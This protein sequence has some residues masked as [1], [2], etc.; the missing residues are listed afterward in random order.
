M[1]ICLSHSSLKF[2][3]MIHDRELRSLLH[4]FGLKVTAARLRVLGV[5]VH[6]PVAL[7]HRD[8]LEKMG[9]QTT[10]KV[11]LYRTLHSFADCGLIHKVATKE[12][13]WRYA[14]HNGDP[15]TIPHDGDHAHFICDICERIYC[16]PAVIPDQKQQVELK[17]GFSLRSEEYRLHGTCPQC[18]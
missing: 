6:S 12:R 11:T 13:S 16:M 8:I 5:L 3:V 4:K 10:D 1:R 9:E 17:R 7:S 14:L 2:T 18:H 15:D